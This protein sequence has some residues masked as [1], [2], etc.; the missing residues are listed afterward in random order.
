MKKINLVIM[1][2]CLG[3]LLHAQRSDKQIE[4][5]KKEVQEKV[6]SRSKMAQV[7]VDKVFSFAEL[8]FQEV[9]TSKYITDILK[10][11]GFVIEYG[12]S[13]VPTAW[14]AKWGSGSPVIAIGSDIDCIPEARSSLLRSH[15]RRST[16]AW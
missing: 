16:R 12:I 3:S 11:N 13:G 1:M 5:L 6:V 15:C 7:M 10:E 14:W 4:G 8:G 9:E 2:I